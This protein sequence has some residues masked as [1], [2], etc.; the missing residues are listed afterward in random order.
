M[1]DRKK[2]AE[3]GYIWKESGVMTQGRREVEV[4]TLLL[5]NDKNNIITEKVLSY[6]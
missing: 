1:S 3:K 2:P 6:F 5:G 4:G